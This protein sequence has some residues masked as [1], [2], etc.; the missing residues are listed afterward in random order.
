V[1]FSPF[2]F[3]APLAAGGIT[4]MAFN[5]LQFA[6]PHG[7]GSVKLSDIRWASL[8]PTQT[9]LY[10]LLV[11]LMLVLTT[12]NLLLM[13]VFLKDLAQWVAA[14]N[15]YREFMSGPP[16]R[17]T[18]IFVPIASLAM[19][20]AVVFASA[21]FFIPSV[22]ANA[23]ALVLPGVVLF[24]VL[25]L[26]A[27][28]L[29][30]RVIRLL[31]C[32]HLDAAKLNFVWLLDV[33]AFGLL[34]LAGTGLASLAANRGI[35]STT[36]FASMLALGVGTL[37]LAGKLVLLVYIQA[38]SRALPE[39]QLLPAFF[40]VVPITCL[41]GISYYR[42]MLL[43]QKWFALDVK[44][45]SYALITVGYIVA[46]TWALVTVYALRDYF[47]NYFRTSEYFPTQ[48]AMV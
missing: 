12:L 6:I 41:Y 23:Q 17:I 37:L 21:P 15:G 18:G 5:W 24:T 11:G 39:S 30:A 28:W 8:S 14:G 7:A 31:L 13:A 29:E 45:P 43:A 48:W 27:F 20:V 42:I 32:Q 38:K 16:S 35:A 44:A 25:L 10:G 4:L 9:G 1:K 26:A 34:A 36:A 3:Q 22:S 2:N 33:F 47:R 19:T 46:V 40:L